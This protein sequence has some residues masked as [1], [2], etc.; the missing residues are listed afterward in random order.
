[1][2][3][4]TLKRVLAWLG[5]GLWTI[6][7]TV[8]LTLL[9]SFPLYLANIHWLKLTE[10]GFTTGQLMTDYRQLMAYLNFPWVN[11][12]QM[13]DFAS[14][15]AGTQHFADVKQLFLLAWLLLLISTPIA[16]RFLFV[17]RRRRSGYLLREPAWLG[18]IVPLVLLGLAALDFDRFFVMFHHLF[19]RNSNWLFDPQTDPVIMV[20]PETFFAQCF[21]LAFIIFE[22][23]MLCGIVVARRS[24]KKLLAAV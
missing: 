10:F 9:G 21:A 3:W 14:S 24:R 8:C 18:A 11:R 5:L 12:L 23:L 7:L 15:V 17:L 19:F 16:L 2:I 1:M 22:I 13:A 20:L 6:S 4:V